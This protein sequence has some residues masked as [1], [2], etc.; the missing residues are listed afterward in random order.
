MADSSSLPR[1]WIDD[2]FG[3][4]RSLSNKRLHAFGDRAGLAG[5]P[6][7]L[8]DFQSGRRLQPGCAARIVE[9][10]LSDVPERGGPVVHPVFRGGEPRQ[11]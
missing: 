5:W 6:R 4:A 2:L 9:Q 1:I 8:D 10:M 11:P 7:G 3:R